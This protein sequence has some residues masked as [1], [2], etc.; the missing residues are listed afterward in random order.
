MKAMSN[1]QDLARQFNEEEAIWQRFEERRRL[2][3]LSRRECPLPESILD[4]LDW[5]NSE[6]EMR[7]TRAIAQTVQ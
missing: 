5:M 2:R 7:V 1:T 3:R 4:E 6:R